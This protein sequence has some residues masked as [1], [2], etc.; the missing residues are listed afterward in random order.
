MT[1][2]DNPERGRGAQDEMRDDATDT[3]LSEGGPH[4]LRIRRLGR[5]WFGVSNCLVTFGHRRAPVSERSLDA[6]EAAL[7][8]G[9]PMPES[10]VAV[11][12]APEDPACASI[13]R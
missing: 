8:H 2:P 7:V 11:C 12:D 6:A 1:Q 9:M 4:V 3:G 13:R 5:K 10:P